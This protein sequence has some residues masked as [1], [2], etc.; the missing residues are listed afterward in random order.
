LTLHPNQLER[1]EAT[2]VAE[3]R[4][5]LQEVLFAWDVEGRTD[6]VDRIDVEPK[7]AA[8]NSL[9]P[10]ERKEPLQTQ[11]ALGGTQAGAEGAFHEAGVAV[12]VLSG[13]DQAAVVGT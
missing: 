4:A 12:T 8:D 6:V 10:L 9:Q 2:S 7:A 5:R 1:L 11:H 3:L 13:Q